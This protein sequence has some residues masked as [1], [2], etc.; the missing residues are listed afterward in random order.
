MIHRFFRPFFGGILLDGELKTSSRM[1]E[2]VFKM[3]SEGDTSVPARGM[4]AIP[5][6]IAEKFQQ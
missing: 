5:A 6:Q 2:F 3:L 4:G 1:F